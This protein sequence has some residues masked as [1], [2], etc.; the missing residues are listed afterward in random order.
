MEYKKS[1]GFNPT[2]YYVYDKKSSLRFFV[3]QNNTGK[4]IVIP[5]SF[6]GLLFN[7]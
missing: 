5:F 1:E 6:E 4:Y 2:V 3:N 7:V